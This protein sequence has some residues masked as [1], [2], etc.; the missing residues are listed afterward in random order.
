MKALGFLL[1]CSVAAFGQRIGAGAAG[2]NSNA[3]ARPNSF[4]SITGCGNVVYPGTGHA[5]VIN[6]SVTNLGFG[7][8]LGA[9][10]GGV[11]VNPGRGVGLGGGRGRGFGGGGQSVVYVPYA[12]G[13]GYYGGPSYYGDPNEAA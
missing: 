1:L 9:T 5:P 4:G 7:Q 10:V 6:N 11:A 2:F 3:Y 8:R 13:G 12:V